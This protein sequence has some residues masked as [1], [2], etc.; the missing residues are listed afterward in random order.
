LTSL[1]LDHIHRTVRPAL[2]AYLAAEQVLTAAQVAG[3]EAASNVARGEVMRAARTAATELHHLT[4]YALH[5]PPP[6]FADVAAVRAAVQS[7][8]L[9]LREPK[10]PIPDD[11]ALLRDT[12]EAFK[13]FKLDRVSATLADADAVATISTGYGVARWGEGKWGGTEQCMV[14]RKDGDVRAMTSLLQNVFDAWMTLLGQPL[15]PIGEY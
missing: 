12:A 7:H 3:D 6:A 8:V 2:R 1:I 11:V 15:A 14:T 9:F 13:H 4:D 5:H 10:A